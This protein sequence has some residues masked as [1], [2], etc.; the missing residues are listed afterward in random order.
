MRDAR[1]ERRCERIEQR[2]RERAENSMREG[3]TVA[4]HP[5]QGFFRAAS[6]FL[7]RAIRARARM[8]VRLAFAC[9]SIDAFSR[10][11]A[12]GFA[13]PNRTTR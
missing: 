3:R 5:V 13:G 12:V 4:G 11:A 8:A 6:S 9:L 2:L 10:L 1:G 7:A